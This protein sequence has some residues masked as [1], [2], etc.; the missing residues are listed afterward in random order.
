MEWGGKL[1]EEEIIERVLEEEPR[2]E[3]IMGFGVMLSG[4][5][6]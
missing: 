2:S 1:R 5:K 3:E 6:P 4:F